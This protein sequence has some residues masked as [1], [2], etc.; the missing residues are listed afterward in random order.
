MPHW[1]DGCCF[2]MVSP[3]NSLTHLQLG[4]TTHTLFILQDTRNTE[5]TCCIG[6]SACLVSTKRLYS[7]APLL[8]TRSQQNW[9]Y[10][11]YWKTSLYTLMY[12]Y[13]DE[14]Q[15]LC[16]TLS[17][18][19]YIHFHWPDHKSGCVASWFSQTRHKSSPVQKALIMHLRLI[20]NDLMN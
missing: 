7:T 13:P 12:S 5:M 20:R 8:A 9:P 6:K 2:Q 17:F 10:W 3:S 14:L 1:E 11:S 4:T 16:I 15:M 18:T 19:L